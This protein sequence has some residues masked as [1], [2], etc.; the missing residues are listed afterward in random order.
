[1]GYDGSAECDADCHIGDLELHAGRSS[2]NSPV[3]GTT[4]GAPHPA[5]RLFR[6]APGAIAGPL[7]DQASS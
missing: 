5:G 3:R 1:M 7:C 6:N 4:H 2:Q